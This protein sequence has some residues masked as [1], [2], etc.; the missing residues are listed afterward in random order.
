M[1]EVFTRGSCRREGDISGDRGQELEIRIKQ[2]AKLGEE[3]RECVWDEQKRK[4]TTGKA[5][6]I[7][8]Q[9][10]RVDSLPRRILTQRKSTMQPLPGQRHW[11]LS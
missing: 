3:E 4:T 1:E 5:L 10:E 7:K 8:C 9:R 2:K 11:H 6:D